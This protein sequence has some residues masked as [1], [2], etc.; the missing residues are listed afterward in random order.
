MMEKITR[1]KVYAMT[2]WKEKCFAVSAETLVDLAVTDLTQ[3]GGI[4]GGN[5]RATEF[6][7]LALKMLQIAPEREIVIEFIKNE[8]HKYARLL[9]A[10]YLRL[11]GNSAEVYRYLEP[12]LNDYRK[13]RR[14]VKSGGCELTTV[15]AF[16]DELLTKDFCCDIALPRLAKRFALEATG[17]LEERKSLLEEEVGEGEDFETVIEKAVNEEMTKR[18]AMAMPGETVNVDGDDGED[19]G[20]ATKKKR[21]LEEK[22]EE[23]EEEEEGEKKSK[24]KKKKTEGKEEDVEIAEANALRLKLGLKPLRG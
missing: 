16:I 7:C 11:V 14:R 19:D 9:G 2:F 5:N 15:D 8:D 1:D 21:S 22:E 20:A 3:I 6:L 23:E 24:K 18:R 17:A 4:Y 10:F 13:V 12:L